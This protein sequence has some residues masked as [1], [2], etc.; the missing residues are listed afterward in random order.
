MELK[1]LRK[2]IDAIDLEILKL[3]N[4]RTACALEIGSIKKSEGLDSYVPNREDEIVSRI[5]K[6]NKGPFPNSGL[7]AVYREL[8]SATRFLEESTNPIGG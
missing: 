1:D 5:I 7:T 8:M 4:Q 6:L 3:L 2:K